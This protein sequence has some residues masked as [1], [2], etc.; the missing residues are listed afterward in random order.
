MILLTPKVRDHDKSSV[1]LNRLTC[2]LPASSIATLRDC[3]VDRGVSEPFAR[4][5]TTVSLL[6]SIHAFVAKEITL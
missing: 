5:L 6:N 2:E 4:R 3:R 1:I